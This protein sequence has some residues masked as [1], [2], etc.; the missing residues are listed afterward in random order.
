[1]KKFRFTLLE[2]LVVITIILI[3]ASV[4]LPSLHKA[5]EYANQIKCANTVRQLFFFLNEYTN[6]QGGFVVPAH[7]A[8]S[9]EGYACFWAGRLARL[10]YTPKGPNY[11]HTEDYQKLAG[12]FACDGNKKAYPIYNIYYGYGLNSYIQN[13]KTTKLPAP[14]STTPLC[15]E[16]SMYYLPTTEETF[17]NVEFCHAAKAAAL[18]L[19]GHVTHYKMSKMPV[20]SW[21]SWFFGRTQW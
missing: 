2:L 18:F 16:G 10:G 6:D 8:D 11:N 7:L 3:L 13:K 5:K 14:P 19:D 17:N 12:V 9:A 20:P 15:V 1:M 4:L 21:N